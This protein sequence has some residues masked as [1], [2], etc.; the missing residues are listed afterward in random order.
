MLI[1]VPHTRLA[2]KEVFHPRPP[3]LPPFV[4][5]ECALELPTTQAETR[6]RASQVPSA[7]TN[8]GSTTVRHTRPVCRHRCREQMR[9]FRTMLGYLLPVC[10]VT[11][12]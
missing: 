9:L 6:M 4:L 8:D 12:R 10:P 7:P 1:S 11:Q 5:L 3:P 2:T